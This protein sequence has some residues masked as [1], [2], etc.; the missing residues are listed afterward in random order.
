MPTCTMQDSWH[1]FFFN[2]FDPAGFV[3]VDKPPLGLWVQTISAAIFEFNGISL[4]LPQAL[5]G[6]LS[7]LVLYHLVR[8]T[9]GPPAGLIAALVL[10]VT[11][12]FVAANRNNTQDSLLV[13]VLLLA[14]WA[15]IRAT[16]TGRL[17]WLLVCAVLVGLGF[18]IKMLQAFLVVPA[19]Y[20]L[21]LLGASV[22]WWERPIHLGLAT[23][24]ML[25]VS[26]AWVAAVDLTP[27][28]E[29]PYV[30]SSSNN[31]VVEL[32]IGHNGLSRL[33]PGGKNWLARTGIVDTSRAPDGGSNAPAQTANSAQP[34]HLPGAP[35]A[36][37]PPGDGTKKASPPGGQPGQPGPPDGNGPPSQDRMDGGLSN[38]TGEPGLLRLFNHQLAG[39][40]S[41]LLPLAG[42][43]LLAAAWQTRLHLPL[44]R[45]HQNLLLW[46]VWLFPMLIFFSMANL[47]H[48]YYLEMLAPAIAALVGAGVVAM[49]EDYARPATTRANAGRGWLLP[50]ALMGSATIEVLILSEFPDWSLWLTPIVLGTC[51]LTGMVLAVARLFR[52]SGRQV[53]AGAVAAVGV[54]ALLVPMLVWASIPVLHG[55]HAGLPY[56]GPDLLADSQ[57]WSERGS[58]G[59]EQLVAFLQA[60]QGDAT[61]LA[62][63]MR[64]TTASPLILATGEPVMAMGGFSGGDQILT[65]DELREMVTEGEVRYFLVSPQEGQRNGLVR[66]VT[67]RCAAVPQ[68]AWGTTPSGGPGGPTQVYDCGTRSLKP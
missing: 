45:W 41:W 3:T 56:A 49:W 46:A 57:G 7:V 65:V 44:G 25:L 26:F 18:N 20:V 48:R 34:G 61:Y 63:T 6:V 5:A 2:A 64:A 30:G 53:W 9:F 59:N 14:A 55:G 17:R 15:I 47:F 38:E 39:Q 35:P 51:F 60:N 22:R 42:I 28:E 4:L 40:I 16:E 68:Q 27:A 62:A 23:V 32:I 33:L 31:T 50:L 12:I 58:L 11:P 13:F 67:N 19:F 54:L 66:W 21:Y 36:A 52:G 37:P 1:N 8:R 29:R 10:A 43:G 24:V